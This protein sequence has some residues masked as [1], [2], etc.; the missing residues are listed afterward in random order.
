MVEDFIF[1]LAWRCVRRKPPIRQGEFL[2]NLT[3]GLGNGE[4]G[5]E[6]IFSSEVASIRSFT[7]IQTLLK[8]SFMLYTVH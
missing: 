8:P 1:L 4:F 5:R 3:A 6:E 2:T 7:V